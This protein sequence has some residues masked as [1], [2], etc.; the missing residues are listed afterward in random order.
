MLDPRPKKSEILRDPV[1]H[2]AVLRYRLG[3]IDFAS[4][5]AYCR[6]A[7]AAEIAEVAARLAPGESG[8]FNP[9]LLVERAMQLIDAAD[10]HLDQ[11]RNRMTEGMNRATL[12]AIVRRLDAKLWSKWEEGELLDYPINPLVA[13]IFN[14]I[15][16]MEPLAEVVEE[17]FFACENADQQL[18]CADRRTSLPR[19]GPESSIKD[20]L[21]WAANERRAAEGRLVAA[22]SDCIRFHLARDQS[23][24]GFW[25]L[26]GGGE[27]AADEVADYVESFVPQKTAPEI[28][29]FH[30]NSLLMD[31]EE[32]RPVSPERL[33]WLSANFYDFWKLHRDG[34]PAGRGNV[35]PGEVRELRRESGTKGALNREN[36]RFATYCEAFIRDLG[37]RKLPQERE[38]RKKVFQQFAEES[39]GLA[40]RPARA[41]VVEFLEVLCRG[42]DK[43]PNQVLA[44]LREHRLL[45]FEELPEEKKD[46]IRKRMPPNERAGLRIKRVPKTLRKGWR[47]DEKGIAE[48]LRILQ[49]I[50]AQRGTRKG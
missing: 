11:E 44:D 4:V 33:G 36:K 15:A 1:Q 50:L 31:W 46:R 6:M 9:T 13:P 16:T 27:A 49:P 42:A 19:P 39:L 45:S 8:E 17:G 24:H 30:S 25:V 48:C 5:D 28:L 10:S 47:F 40:T 29:E 35:E 12:E 37:R 22:L 21:R 32:S 23:M 34:Y 20:M 14:R 2:A 3:S 38:A 26:E 41:R 18:E 43:Q 7:G